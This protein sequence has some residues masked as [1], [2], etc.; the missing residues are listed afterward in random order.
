M[1][2]PFVEI[3]HSCG[4]EVITVNNH[5]RAKL[6]DATVYFHTLCLPYYIKQCGNVLR[7]V[8]KREAKENL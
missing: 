5:Y 3:C 8:V 7:D 4:R 6:V 1:R 2:K